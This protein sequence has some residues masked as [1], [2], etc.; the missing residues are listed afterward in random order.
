[1]QYENGYRFEKIPCPIIYIEY[2]TDSGIKK[3]PVDLYYSFG[4]VIIKYIN[5]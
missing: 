3:M 1:M 4:G 2:K 5:I